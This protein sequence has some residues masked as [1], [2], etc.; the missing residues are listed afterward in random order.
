[1]VRSKSQRDNDLNFKP[2]VLAQGGNKL[3]VKFRVFL[4][5]REFAIEILRH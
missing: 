5:C 4:S 2:G 1:M 3:E